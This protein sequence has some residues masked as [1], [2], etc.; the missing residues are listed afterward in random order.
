M[1]QTLNRLTQEILALPREERAQLIDSIT[2]SL[3]ETDRQNEA[4][5]LK[6]CDRRMA[7]F[8]A[9]RMEIYPAEEVFRNLGSED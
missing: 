6:E 1:T 9:G 2:V 7:E 5:W 4:L 3:D 8:D